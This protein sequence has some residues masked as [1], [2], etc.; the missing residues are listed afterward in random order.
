MLLTTRG[1]CEVELVFRFR[2]PRFRVG[3]ALVL[4]PPALPVSVCDLQCLV[5]E[6]GCLLSLLP[7]GT[8]DGVAEEP[9]RARLLVNPRED[10]VMDAAFCRVMRDACDVELDFPF[11][12]HLSQDESGGVDEQPVARH[13]PLL[14]RRVPDL[15]HERRR[16]ATCAPDVRLRRASVAYRQLRLARRDVRGVATPP[17]HRPLDAHA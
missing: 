11:L 3:D 10:A 7:G 12:V 14:G 2:G 4:Q 6:H 8:H 1:R 5:Q 17:E 15:L 9:V 16:D 13:V